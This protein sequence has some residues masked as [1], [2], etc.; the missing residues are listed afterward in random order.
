MFRQIK[1]NIFLVPLVLITALF[2]GLRLESAIKATKPFVDSLTPIILYPHA[3]YDDK[4]SMKYPEYYYFIKEV[5]YI[6]PEDADIYI[7]NINIPYGENMWALTNLNIT[8]SLLYPRRIH[9]FT[10]EVLT[11]HNDPSYIVLINNFPDFPIDDREIY[12][13]NDKEILQNNKNY[14]PENNQNY[15]GLIKL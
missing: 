9:L 6:V 7:P 2:I 12:I 8:S 14:N 10:K 3:S 11:R 4:M 15:K 1:K 5:K 13:L